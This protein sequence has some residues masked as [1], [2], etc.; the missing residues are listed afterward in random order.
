ME[1]SITKIDLPIIDN[2]VRSDGVHISEVIAIAGTAKGVYPYNKYPYTPGSFKAMN[3]QM[4]LG[5]IFEDAMK[6]HV[7]PELNNL[8]HLE[9]TPGVEML[10]E[11]LGTKIY[12]TPDLVCHRS[13]TVFDVKLTWRSSYKDTFNHWPYM[14]QIKAYLYALGYTNGGF[15]TGYL[16]GTY[17]P[18]TPLVELLRLRFTIEELNANWSELMQYLPYAKGESH[19]GTK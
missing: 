7:I 5:L 15:I 3:D 8:Y 16:N 17:K 4:K 18:P 14:S 12:F 13:G 6:M 10:T 1:H 19:G 9:L 11:H 2:F